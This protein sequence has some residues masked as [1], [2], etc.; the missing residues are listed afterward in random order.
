MFTF[1]PGFEAA[2]L[3]F[4]NMEY[5]SYDGIN[6]V[7]TAGLRTTAGSNYVQA[8]NGTNGRYNLVAV[9]QDGAVVGS[10]HDGM[11]SWP[12]PSVDV[13]GSGQFMS[14]GGWSIPPRK[15][16]DIEKG[17]VLKAE[18]VKNFHMKR[19]VGAIP[20]GLWG[21]SASVNAISQRM[22]GVGAPCAPGMNGLRASL[23]SGAGS[24]LLGGVG[25]N[26]MYAIGPEALKIRE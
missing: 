2:A 15:Q 1:S 23:I 11:S 26:D 10:G 21:T 4:P 7:G 3:R 6:G 17:T 8:S 19:G 13:S 20:S 25:S 16:V 22:T 12:A 24:G 9:N 5:T 18:M 14:G